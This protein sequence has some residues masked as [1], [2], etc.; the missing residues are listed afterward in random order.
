M[1]FIGVLALDRRWSKLRVNGIEAIQQIS[2]RFDV[3]SVFLD[4][5][6]GRCDGC[7]DREIKLRA[8]LVASREHA[9][10]QNDRNHPIRSS[11]VAAISSL[12]HS[13]Y[14]FRRRALV[15]NVIGEGFIA[16][17]EGGGALACGC[18]IGGSVGLHELEI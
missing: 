15:E 6:P 16:A 3:A 13:D 2:E 11:R 14:G 1:S 18:E 4:D 5:L 10:E 8:F 17:H 7:A 12:E 9:R